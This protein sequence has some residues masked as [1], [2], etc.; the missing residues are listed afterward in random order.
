MLCLSF[1]AV[2]TNSDLST[3]TYYP[4]H[5]STCSSQLL[6]KRLGKYL[7]LLT[8]VGVDKLVCSKVNK[9]KHSDSTA[10]QQQ[11]VVMQEHSRVNFFSLN[12]VRQLKDFTAL[13][14]AFSSNCSVIELSCCE[15]CFHRC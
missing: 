14:A 10:E 9:L 4:Q 12:Y 8:D 3:S 7:K 1:F 13:C 6:S 2:V 5:T 11:S 15:T